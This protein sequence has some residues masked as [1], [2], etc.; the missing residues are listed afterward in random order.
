M[1]DHYSPLAA[2]LLLEALGDG[3][4]PYLTVRSDSM[5]PLLRRGDQI[6]L[7]PL[8]ACAL[9]VG[10]IIVLGTPEDLLAHRYWGSLETDGSSFVLTRGDRLA[11]F[12]PISPKAQVQAVVTMR[13][14]AGRHLALDDGAGKWLNRRLARLA[15]LEARVM[16]LQLTGVGL[17]VGHHAQYGLIRR[18][19]R[20]MIYTLAVILTALVG[21]LAK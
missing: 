7:C 16:R 2:D 10:E 6:Q 13:R 19:A 8:S 1:S 4:H 15:D 3:R 20:R 17:E 18:L 11:F 9:F 21:R 12:D 14:R 5:A